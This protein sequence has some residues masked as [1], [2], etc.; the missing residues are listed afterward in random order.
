MKSE[1]KEV[2]ADRSTKELMEFKQAFQLDFKNGADPDFVRSRM[3]VIDEILGER[4]EPYETLADLKEALDAGKHPNYEVVVDNDSVHAAVYYHDDEGEETAWP[5]Y[6]WSAK[7]DT[8]REVLHEAFALLGI[9]SRD[10]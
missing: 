10:C 8:P 2:Y 3:D 1:F 4:D 9:K 6:L 5:D 7:G